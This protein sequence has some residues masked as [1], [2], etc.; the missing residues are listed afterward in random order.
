MDSGITNKEPGFP[1][2]ESHSS[3]I[4]NVLTNVETVNPGVVLEFSLQ[5]LCYVN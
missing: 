4:E 5:T 3:N 2:P 1:C